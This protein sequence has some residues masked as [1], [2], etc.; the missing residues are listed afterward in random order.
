M[1]HMIASSASQPELSES[2][3]SGG[4][5]AQY[6]ANMGKTT[7]AAFRAVDPISVKEVL[8]ADRWIAA[9]IASVETLP[10]S[11]SIATAARDRYGF[12]LI[13]VNRHFEKM[14]GYSRE[15]VIGENCKFLQRD[16]SGAM[17]PKNTCLRLLSN[18]LRLGEA[19]I[20]TLINFKKDGARFRVMLGV[21][22]V[23]D[24]YRRYRYVIGVHLDVSESLL[25]ETHE[26]E[27]LYLLSLQMKLEM[28]MN[29]MPCTL[30]G[31]DREV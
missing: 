1:A 15:E 27:S 20:F 16:F 12:P 17:Y 4:H 10:V 8:T 13:Y 14:T 5:S 6:P 11:V 28:A 9:F 30:C 22:P 25:M 18:A 19:K 26:R 21:K 7:E 24:I 3:D 2:V 23:R 31:V 29:A